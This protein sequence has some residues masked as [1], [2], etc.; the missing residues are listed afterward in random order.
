MKLSL[1]IVTILVLMSAKSLIADCP[2]GWAG[3]LSGCLTISTKEVNWQEAQNKCNEFNAS[4]ASILSREEDRVVE[5]L[6]LKKENNKKAKINRFWI[7]GK[8]KG[9]HDTNQ[10][11]S[12]W[13]WI[14]G[15]EWV[16]QF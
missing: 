9:E 10:S 15:E 11:Q 2:E 5:E 1:V 13:E 16:Y 6:I 7:G 8:L 12:E 4:L 14:N 3:F